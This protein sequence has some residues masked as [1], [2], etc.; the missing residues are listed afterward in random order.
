MARDFVRG[1]LHKIPKM[2][3]T[4]ARLLDHPWIA[5]LNKNRTTAILEEEEEEDG[6]LTS[7]A[8]PTPK[9]GPAPVPTS[10]RSDLPA[11]VVDVEVASW[12]LDAIEKKRKGKLAKNAKPALHAAPLDAIPSPAANSEGP[13]G[14][15]IMVEPKDV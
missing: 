7:T 2:R 15:G 12:V 13:E 8:D 10:T 5:D 4:Y 3:P 11:N 14:P 9:T 1:C 6:T